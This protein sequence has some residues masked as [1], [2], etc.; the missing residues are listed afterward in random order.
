VTVIR[1]VVPIAVV[2]W[3]AGV[4]AEEVLTL[5]RAVEIARRRHPFVD[6]QRAQVVIAR[7]RT[8]QSA[9]SMFPFLTGAF[10][11]QPQTANSSPIPA[12]TRT[13][14][15]GTVTVLDATGRP[16]VA[17]C[18]TPGMGNCLPT[19]KFPPSNALVGWWNIS[20]GVA[21]TPWDWGRS[22]FG[23]RSARSA[24]D[25]SAVGVVT[26]QRNVVLTVKLAF[27]AVRT[28]EEQV[29][30]GLESVTTFQKQLDQIRAFYDAGLRTRIDV[31]TAESALASAELTL[32]QARAGL[33]TAR[34]QLAFSLGED[35]WH[36]WRLVFDAKVFDPL[37]GDETRAHTPEP[38][39]AE[40]AFRQRS[41]LRQ[42]DLLGLSFRQLVRSQRAQ[43]LPQLTLNAGPAWTGLN[44]S[45]LVRNFT[46][47][48]AL[49][50]PLGGMS[51][52]L[53]HGQV[54]E[55]QGN[56]LATLAQERSTRESIRQETVDA[57]ALLASALEQVRAAR[58]L[59]AA[60]TAQRDLAVGRYAAGVGTIIELTNALLTYISARFQ[61]VQAGYDMASA[62]AQLQHAL[63]EDG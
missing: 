61:L 28:A 36:P 9:A 5:D 51:P 59:V 48:V 32:T 58:Q 19:A 50:Y 22:I 39:L 13:A 29:K 52:L 46:V 37:P 41:E 26:V 31:A 23:Y 3:T 42:L 63:G 4:R 40:L 47:S 53:V 17:S 24:A 62:R 43:Y 11:Y 30:V 38:S 10:A 49:E 33:E 44:M 7:G 27:F 56:L 20:V 18:P 1:L 25:S 55:A 35:S 45:T 21:W 8:Q 2:L 15:R 6:A 16:V 57:R 12:N 34:A 60:A 54:R 14:T